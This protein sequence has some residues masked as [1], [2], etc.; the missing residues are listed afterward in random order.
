M[1]DD[2]TKK[3]EETIEI[4]YRLYGEEVANEIRQRLSRADEEEIDLSSIVYQ[5]KKLDE[6][7]TKSSC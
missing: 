4:V 5:L 2:M 3:I 6:L 1:G 7:K